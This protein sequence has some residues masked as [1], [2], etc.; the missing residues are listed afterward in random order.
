MK[1][2]LLAASLLSLLAASALAQTPTQPQTQLA[3]AQTVAVLPSHIPDGVILHCF[4]WKLRD[5]IDELPAIAEAGFTAI[6][7]SPMQRAVRAGDVWYD[8]Y[9][10]YDYR[11]IDNAMGTRADM[12]ELC[13]KAADLGIKVIVD[14]VANHG[15]GKTEAHDP[16][17]D[18]NGRMRWNTGGIDYSNRYS[19]T[20]NELGG[21]GDSNSDDPDVQQRTLQYVQ[22]L[23]SLGVSGL[24]W[25]AAKHIQLPSEGCEFWNVVLSEPG[26]WSYGEI[27]G[28]PAGGSG[29]SLLREYTT[30]MRVTDSGFTGKYAHGGHYDRG[31]A[32]DKL[33]YWAESHDTYCNAGQTASTPEEEIDRT[34][35]LVAS[36]LGATALYLS[37]PQ[38]K[39]NTAIKVATKGSTHFTS[40]QVAAVNHFH[41]AMGSQPEAFAEADGAMVVYR[42]LGAVIVKAGGGSVAV[43]AGNLVSGVNYKDEVTGSTFTLSGGML[44]GEVDPAF[45]IAVVYDY[46]NP[47]LPATSV[48]VSDAGSTFNSSSFTLSI[49]PHY[50]LEAHYTVNG[51]EP[52]PFTGVARLPL[53][54]MLQD[55]ETAHVEWFAHGAANDA[56]GSGD[57]TFREKPAEPVRVLLHFDDAGWGTNFYTFIYDSSGRNNGSWPGKKMTIDRTIT[58]NGYAGDWFVYT[59]PDEFI[60]SGMAMVSNN[61]P[62]RHPGNNEPGIPIDGKTLVF[63][64][65]GGVW[66]TGPAVDISSLESVVAEEARPVAWYT[67]TGAQVAQ[68][69]PGHMYIVRYSDGSARKFIAPAR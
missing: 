38:S 30:M 7:T 16:W 28:T 39:V 22:E 48:T 51:G 23:K 68:P 50:A 45:G 20:H 17:W 41:N 24:R 15:T 65:H 19:E 21:Y 69:A 25:D 10:P 64:H 13:Q 14:I 47:P 12:Q 46:E 37:R 8:V 2:R 60:F 27:L 29:T 57:Y 56:Q 66:T 52:V 4:C 1:I 36:R 33:V 18:E 42:T 6:Q 3:P 35:A 58:C 31:I 59:V 49:E 63:M 5:I 11:F 67:T 54:Q 43:P 26:I 53:G 34:W 44:R 61:G 32:P 40:P 55:G 62:Y 9:R